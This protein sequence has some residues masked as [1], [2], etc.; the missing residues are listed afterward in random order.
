MC[1]LRCEDAVSNVFKNQKCTWFPVPRALYKNGHL[2]H[3]GG[4]A[5]KLYDLLMGLAQEHSAVKLE[6]P[7]YKARDWAGLTAETVP[8]ARRELE[9]AG[10]VTCKKGEHGVMT[11][12]LLN[13]ETQVP[14]PPP[15]GRS[16]FFPAPPITRA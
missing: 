11:Y 3:L 9:A 5:V 4:S 6:L 7:A 12:V 2:R 13:P 8:I 10:L 14:L 16:G 15:V 1:V